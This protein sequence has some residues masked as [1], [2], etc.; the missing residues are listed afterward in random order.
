MKKYVVQHELMNESIIVLFA[1]INNEVPYNKEKCWF[2]MTIQKIFYT[3][4]NEMGL[5]F[6]EKENLTFWRHQDINDSSYTEWKCTMGIIEKV[7]K[8]YEF[9]DD[10]VALLWFRL[11][12]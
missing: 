6:K 1:R 11:N 2:D 9:E 5:V 4:F 10:D 3:T 8:Y 12:Y 7:V